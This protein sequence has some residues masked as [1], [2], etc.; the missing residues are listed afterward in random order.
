M[1]GY[2]TRDVLLSVNL[3]C[4]LNRESRAIRSITF[5][6]IIDHLPIERQGIFFRDI[7]SANVP[8]LVL[9][10]VVIMCGYRTGDEV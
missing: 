9:L 8:D 6:E 5:H 10:R 1:C 7:P 4:G 2:K 3:Y